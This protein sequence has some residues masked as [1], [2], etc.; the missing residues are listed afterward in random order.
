MDR[1][2][3]LGNAGLNQTDSNSNLNYIVGAGNSGTLL[4]NFTVAWWGTGGS[5]TVP[6]DTNGFILDANTGGGNGGHNAAGPISG[7]G[8]YVITHGPHTSNAWNNPYTISG[9]TPNT[10]TG[11]TIIKRGQIVLAKTAGVDALPG[12]GTITLGSAGETARLQWAASNQINDNAT[13]IVLLPTV[14]DGFAPDANLN[15]LDLAGFSDT[16]ASLTLPDNTGTKTQVRTGTGGVLTVTNLT[17]NGTAMPS[18]TYTA[19]NTTW[20]TG[21]GS[22]IVPYQGTP[23]QIWAAIN[24]GGQSA[25][26]DFNNDGVSNGLAYFMGT[27]ASVAATTPPIIAGKVTW[28]RDPTATITFWKVQYSTDL[29]TWTDVIPPDASI[30]TSDPTKVVYTLPVGSV[31]QF[32]RLVV[33]P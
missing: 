4:G 12:V 32:C 13:I 1:T 27:A 29:T 15:Y 18:G 31:M 24:V 2:Q 17:V 3:V 14:S 8:S 16:I 23:F 21:T 5:F 22:V 7:T 30:D 10:Y 19:T 25:S 28:P 6:L 26:E 20:I 9:A 11:G 33:V